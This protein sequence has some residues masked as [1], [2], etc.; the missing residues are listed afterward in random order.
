LYSHWWRNMNRPPIFMIGPI[1][2]WDHFVSSKKNVTAKR[3]DVCKM[4]QWKIQ[5]NILTVP[6]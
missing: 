6:T 3:L 2:P 5:R 1:C 4:R